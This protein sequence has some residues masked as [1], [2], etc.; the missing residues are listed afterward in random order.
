[1]APSDRQRSTAVACS[2]LEQIVGDVELPERPLDPDLLDA[3]LGQVELTR[4]DHVTMGGPQRGIIG[5]R[6]QQDARVR[7]QLG[8]RYSDALCR[9]T[10]AISASTSDMPGTVKASAIAPT[11]VLPVRGSDAVRQATGRPYRVDSIASP[12][13]ARRTSSA[14][15]ALASVIETRMVPSPPGVTEI[16]VTLSGCRR[17]GQ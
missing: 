1:M 17:D 11:S 16:P 3:C 7:E 5:K 2:H 8:R 13:S 15:R 14:N 4:R 12:A 6:P 9:N 10:A